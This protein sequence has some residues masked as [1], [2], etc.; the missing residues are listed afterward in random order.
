MPDVS[1]DWTF[2]L[3][4]DEMKKSITSRVTAELGKARSIPFL[5]P[6]LQFFGSA[7]WK[8]DKAVFHHISSDLCC[9]TTDISDHPAGVFLS[10]DYTCCQRGRK[11]TVPRTR[12]S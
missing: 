4:M 11:L 3:A 7:A 1:L 8:S 2:C 6:I 12:R 9:S 10:D 5:P